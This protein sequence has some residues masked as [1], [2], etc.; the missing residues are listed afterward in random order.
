M[1]KAGIIIVIIALLGA[2]LFALKDNNSGSNNSTSQD[3]IISNNNT[4]I[5]TD[6]GFSPQ[7][8]TVQAGDT[9]SVKNTSARVI[10]FDSG[11]HPQHTDDPEINIGEIK[12]GK[13][14]SVKVTIKGS[15]GY[16][17]HLRVSD[18]GTLVVQ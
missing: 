14:S 15:H 11:P 2:G 9:V 3:Q 4:I 13:T 8:L 16:H 6:N 17:N 18:T 1:K 10:D 12:P 5:Y 7:T